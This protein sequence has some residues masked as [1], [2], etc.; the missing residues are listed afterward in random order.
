MTKLICLYGKNSV[1]AAINARPKEIKAIYSTNK[2]F[3]P[4]NVKSKLQ[5]V[6][7]KS[8]LSTL[9]SFSKKFTDQNHQGMCC[10]IEQKTSDTFTEGSKIDGNA[11]LLDR[12]TDIGNISSIIRSGFCFGFQNIISP[13]L[14]SPDPTMP[15]LYSQVNKLSSG[16][17]E[18]ANFYTAKNGLPDA[19]HILQKQ[20][21]KVLALDIKGESYHDVKPKLEG[22]KIAL[23]MGS[24]GGGVSRDIV[25]M[26]D[27]T[28]SIPM[29]TNT[30]VDSLNVGVCAG[31]AM[32]KMYQPK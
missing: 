23:V 24:E 8:F 16:A 13:R 1:F 2:V 15:I 21:Y 5:V 4:D 6:S 31:I 3:I 10:V 14:K 26:C 27:Y 17:S 20:R 19:V 11:I 7:P 30:S 9:A 22:S 12:V 25:N 32:Q 29:N 18:F 28:M